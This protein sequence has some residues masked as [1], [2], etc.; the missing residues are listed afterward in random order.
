M[1]LLTRLTFP[2]SGEEKIPVHQFVAL[3]SELL[4]GAPGV[5]IQTLSASLAL[6]VEEKA[7][8]TAWYVDEY[9]PGVVGSSEVHDVLM[10]AESGIYTLSEARSRLGM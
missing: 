4:R 2:L 10:L 6:S 9:A 1:S 5:D 3:V 7:E 8:F